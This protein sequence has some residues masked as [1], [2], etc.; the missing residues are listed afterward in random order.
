MANFTVKESNKINGYTKINNADELITNNMLDAQH[1]LNNTDGTS[2]GGQD[3]SGGGF[4][5]SI[6]NVSGL[7]SELTTLQN[8]I[9]TKQPMLTGL[10]ASVTEL[11]YTDGVTSNIQTQLNSKASSTHN[12]SGVY[13]P[14]GTYN[15][16][17]GTDTDINTSGSTIIDSI[18]VTDGVITSMGTRT[19]SSSDIGVPTISSGTYTPTIPTN[20]YFSNPRAGMYTRIGNIVDVSFIVDVAM[21]GSGT[22]S[23]Y[24]SIP[25]ASDFISSDDAIGNVTCSDENYGFEMID[26]GTIG[27]IEAK[28]S[29]NNILIAI[30]SSSLDG[31][32]DTSDSY[33]CFANFKYIIK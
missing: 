29:N 14:A 17:I 10:T 7:Q 33:K 2:D 23:T 3:W 19:L 16:V 28:A 20:P 15:T 8:D 18:Y 1:W 5:A 31:A 27:I 11:N 30:A 21:D 9:N 24:V 4:Q 26:G 12:H 13:Q 22:L 6:V 25:V 32:N